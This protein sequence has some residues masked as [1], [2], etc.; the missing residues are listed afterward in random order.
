MFAFRDFDENDI[1]SS[2][3]NLNINEE[4]KN[5][6]IGHINK[7]EIEI[8]NKSKKF[9]LRKKLIFNFNKEFINPKENLGNKR[10]LARA[11]SCPNVKNLV[12]K[13]LNSKM[14]YNYYNRNSKNNLDIMKKVDDSHNITASYTKWRDT[15]MIIR[16]K[17]NYLNTSSFLDSYL[18]KP[19]PD[20]LRKNDV[21][22][23][24]IY[25][26]NQIIIEENN[27]NSIL[28]NSGNTS[29]VKNNEIRKSKQLRYSLSFG[30]DDEDEDDESSYISKIDSKQISIYDMDEELKVLKEIG[31]NIKSPNLKTNN[32]NNS[33][34]KNNNNN[35]NNNNG[36]IG[37]NKQIST[38]KNVN[39][40]NSNI[41]KKLKISNT[42]TNKENPIIFCNNQ[43]EMSFHEEI[44]DNINSNSS[45]NRT[46][47]RNSINN[48]INKINF[49]NNIHNTIN[50]SNSI[51]QNNNKL[52]NNIFNRNDYNDIRD[53]NPILKCSTFNMTHK[54][55]K[56]DIII[57]YNDKKTISKLNIN[58]LKDDF[59]SVN[60]IFKKHAN[61]YLYSYFKDIST[62]K[63]INIKT[64]KNNGFPN[65][66][67]IE[68][69]RRPHKEN[70]IKK[71]ENIKYI[72]RN[73]N[74]KCCQKK[75]LDA[76]KTH[77]EKNVVI[78]ENNNTTKKNW[79][80]HN[81]KELI[82]NNGYAKNSYLKN[83]YNNKNNNN[84]LTAK[85]LKKKESMET[86]NFI[87]NS[88]KKISKLEKDTNKKNNKNPN[89]QNNI[90][91]KDNNNDNNKEKNKQTK[92]N[93]PEKLKIKSDLCN[94]FHEE[95]NFTNISDIS[96]IKALSILSPT[97][98]NTNLENKNPNI[99]ENQDN[100]L[101]S[102]ILQNKS[103]YISFD[104]SFQSQYPNLNKSKYLSSNLSVSHENEII[105]V[106]KNKNK[107]NKEN[108]I[109]NY[110]LNYT[111]NKYNGRVKKIIDISNSH[112]NIE[113]INTSD[114][115]SWNLLNNFG[116][117]S[118]RI[119]NYDNKK[120]DYN[121]LNYVNQNNY[122][123]NY[124]VTIKKRNLAEKLKEEIQKSINKNNINFPSTIINNGKTSSE[125]NNNKN[126]Y[127]DDNLNNS[128]NPIMYNGNVPQSNGKT[129]REKIIR[130]TKN[131]N[132][133]RNNS[134]SKNQQTLANNYNDNIPIRH[135]DLNHS[136][137]VTQY[138]NISNTNSNKNVNINNS[139]NNSIDNQSD[140]FLGNNYIKTND[141]SLDILFNSLQ[142]E[143]KIEEYKDPRR[144]SIIKIKKRFSNSVDYE[145]FQGN[146]L[147]SYKHTIRVNKSRIKSN[148][149]TNNQNSHMNNNVNNITADKN[150][151]K[152][153]NSLLKNNIKYKC[154][155]GK[156]K[157]LDINNNNNI[158]ILSKHRKNYDIK[159]FPEKFITCSVRDLN[160]YG[161][162]RK[163]LSLLKNNNPK[164][165]KQVESSYILPKAKKNNKSI[166]KKVSFFK[167]NNELNKY[168]KKNSISNN[169]NCD[170]TNNKN[171]NVNVNRDKNLYKKYNKFTHRSSMEL[172]NNF[173]KNKKQANKL[174]K[175]DDNN[176]NGKNINVDNMSTFKKERKKCGY[177]YGK[178]NHI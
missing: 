134:N 10:H 114:N 86:N 155:N 178:N 108:T 34:G 4:N 32:N 144:K 9:S 79:H 169:L 120:E 129:I 68:N 143:N 110:S 161:K 122:N 65:I 3:S 45:S 29:N 132:I 25:D 56:K 156:V 58:N 93:K 152:N 166:N 84:N 118:H 139:I 17:K 100:I 102:N 20:N 53:S 52:N 18:K 170:L 151:S 6:E 172:S 90:N 145:N 112:L 49:T 171:S 27:N 31:N 133:Y 157:N 51:I 140:R 57:F 19:H 30:D 158:I 2:N 94:K 8:I 176:K 47:N 109:S 138:I 1:N 136:R 142:T 148:G 154:L 22:N 21:K 113:E 63:K 149:K 167:N 24:L 7:N 42:N 111:N 135:Y 39:L 163:N 12:T 67:D 121:N 77:R 168:K 75:N 165:E 61:K 78:V 125:N 73:S 106:G 41:N 119:Y 177:S 15:S 173:G 116:N 5:I 43:A 59:F 16:R 64:D 150:N 89:L 88:N 46:S 38:F 99:S 98:T 101:F 104:K 54:E 85:K 36:C 115:S 126:G 14:R 162:N 92:N 35:N 124:I 80:N 40:R 26:I 33:G 37:S 44:K 28:Q 60:S 103:N 87:D 174:N 107:E 164:K 69:I 105:C 128:N 141:N 23:S 74:N 160:N 13:L 130:C 50:R 97:Y 81:S 131:S 146:N 117:Y 127:I 76:I 83:S 82:N 96:E 123:N 147:V 72:H 66:S 175:E 62:I 71:K 55:E 48:K 70:K 11:K 91:N 159:N 153:N 137:Y 95:L